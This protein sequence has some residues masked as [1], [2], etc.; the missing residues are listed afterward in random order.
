MWA[1]GVRG[2]PYR[3]YYSEFYDAE[4]FS[5]KAFGATGTAAESGSLD[6]DPF[7]DP[8][9]IVGAVSFQDR[10]YVFMRRAI[11]EIEGNT[12]NTFVVK[13][14]SREFGTVS[15]ASIVPIGNDVMYASERGILRL[16]SSDKAVETESAMAS[17]PISKIWNKSID[18]TLQAQF[19]ATYDEAENLYLISVASKGSDE[20]DIVL[21]Y[22]VENGI[23]SG[24]WDGYRARCL[25]TYLIDGV[26]RVICGRED[27][28][29]S[30]T[31]DDARLDLGEP[32][33]A[34]LKTGVLY[35]G[36]EIDLQYVWNTATVLASTTG[37][38]SLTFNAY[39]DS[40]LVRTENIQI[41]SGE[42]L[43]GSSFILGQSILGSGQFTPQTFPLNDQGYGLQL[44]VIFNSEADVE[45]YGFMVDATAVD[46]HIG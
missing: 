1:F 11:F 7:G 37:V 45:I 39:V 25:A 44:E 26:S 30:V 32:F 40:R 29:I 33:V 13:P 34:Y 14:I 12:I 20:N 23:W 8:E 17:R 24:V 43:L 42:D 21:A 3:I 18:R 41:K 19:S 9:G 22:N 36:D 6:L 5:I 28:V 31:G 16:S 27:G 2:F 15:H 38:A 10:L 35:P 46:H 4:Q